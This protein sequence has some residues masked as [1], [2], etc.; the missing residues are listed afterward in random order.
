MIS[1]EEDD[2]VG[3]QSRL[4]LYSLYVQGVPRNMTIGE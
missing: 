1:P 2:S 3:V 4:A